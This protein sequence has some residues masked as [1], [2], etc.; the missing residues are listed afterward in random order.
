M[1]VGIDARFYGG[2]HATGLGRY[3]QKLI[4]YLG[5]VAEPDDEFVIF[6]RN[7]NWDA[8]TPAS[9][10]FRKVLADFRWYSLEEQTRFPAVLNRE[11]CDILHFPHFNVPA[12]AKK[13]FLV[14]I[15]DLTL[16]HFPTIRATTLGPLKYAVKH[17]AYTL[18]IRR[19]VKRASRILTVSQFSKNDIVASFNVPDSKVVVTYEAADPICD[20]PSSSQDVLSSLRL[21][22]AYALYVGNAYPHKNLEIFPDVI[23][24]LARLGSPLSIVCVGKI[25]YFYERLKRLIDKRGLADRILCVG[26]VPDRDLPELFRRAA[27]YIFPSL[28]EGFGLPPLE[29]MQCGV[30]VLSSHASCLPEIL[31][32]AVQYMDPKNPRDIAEKM[33]SIASDQQVRAALIAKGREH[34]KRYSWKRMAEQTFN[35]YRSLFNATQTQS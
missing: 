6:L 1:R 26:F 27:L 17:A 20:G 10:R 5:D 9:S 3:T 7:E 12:R 28:Y 14:T 22:A 25:D 4:R 18:V 11:H 24:E 33:M 8:Y 30:P 16:T 32:D 15:H 19:A 31:G 13:P 2:A 29:A 35:E 23:H 34:V 21:P